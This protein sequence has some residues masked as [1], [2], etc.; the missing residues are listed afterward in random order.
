MTILRSL[1]IV[2][3]ATLVF[4]A[5]S[6]ATSPHE[7]AGGDGENPPIKPVE[8]TGTQIHTLHTSTGQ[9]Y[10]LYVILPRNYQD[11]TKKFPVLYLLDGQYDF[12]LVN[13][14]YWDL[15]YDGFMPDLITVGI[16][17]GGQHANIDSLRLHDFTPTTIK[18]VPYSGHAPAFLASIKGELIPFVDSKFRTD[19]KDRTLMGSSLGGLFTLY[20]MFHETELFTRYVL[21][22]PS[23]GWDNSV[24]YSYE[25]AYH[26]KHKGL[27]IRLFM[28]YSEFEGIAKPFGKL[29]DQLKS[30]NYE[31]LTMETRLLDGMGHAGSKPEG[32]ARG[33]QSVFARLSKAIDPSKL[34]ALAGRYRLNPELAIS[35]ENANDHIVLIAPD[36][37]R[38]DLQAESANEFFVKGSY[39]FLKFQKNP[40]GAVTGLHVQQFEGALD[41]VKEN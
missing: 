35:I 30:R 31:G 32:Y 10:Q 25:E 34:T 6:L 17:W 21:T 16:T 33:M 22:S 27:P 5:P 12:T 3:G 41:L 29:V 36:S 38:I 20:T 28:A 2:A 4:T 7:G 23:L 8:L 37:T 24:V 26:A 9:D 18:Q 19:K 39:L 40:A 1:L 14:I 13:G 15:F 11:S